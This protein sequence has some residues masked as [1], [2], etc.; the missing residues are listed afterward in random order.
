MYKVKFTKK[1]REPVYLTGKYNTFKQ[2]YDMAKKLADISMLKHEIK[3]RSI[4]YENGDLLEVEMI[5]FTKKNI[6]R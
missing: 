3:E 4:E 2:A 5:A 1:G 6:I